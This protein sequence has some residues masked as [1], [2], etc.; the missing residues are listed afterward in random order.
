MNERPSLDPEA[1]VQ[2][3]MH[4]TSI[5]LNVSL[6]EKNRRWMSKMKESWL[7][8][9]SVYKEYETTGGIL[10]SKINPKPC[11]SNRL[12]HQFVSFYRKTQEQTQTLSSESSCRLDT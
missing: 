2:S 4:T 3:H 9:G 6:Q 1:E 11:Q 7:S 5:P 12:I 8:F 10:Q